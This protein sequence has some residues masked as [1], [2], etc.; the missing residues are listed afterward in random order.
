MNDN[1]TEENLTEPQEQ[2]IEIDDQ[3][4]ES[5]NFAGFDYFIF[6][7]NYIDF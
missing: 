1:S 4:D 5:C 6:N 7:E 3:D 2:K